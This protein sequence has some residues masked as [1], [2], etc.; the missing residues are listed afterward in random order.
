VSALIPCGDVSSCS[1]R[2][3]DCAGYPRMGHVSIPRFAR[4]ESGAEAECGAGRCSN[5][6]VAFVGESVLGSAPGLFVAGSWLLGRFAAEFGRF[7]YTSHTEFSTGLSC[8]TPQ[9]LVGT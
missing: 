4:S 2:G 5:L 1:W 8:M 7:S 6:E 9:T 3:G